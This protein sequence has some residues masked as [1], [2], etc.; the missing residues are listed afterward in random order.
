MLLTSSHIK[1]TRGI[2]KVRA[3]GFLFL[4]RV[5]KTIIKYICLKELLCRNFDI[6]NIIHYNIYILTQRKS[7]LMAKRVKKGFICSKL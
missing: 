4:K 3:L 2:W 1:R 5:F 7:S 6:N